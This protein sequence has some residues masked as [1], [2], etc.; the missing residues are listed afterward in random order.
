MG[1]PLGSFP[2]AW[3][4]VEVRWVTKWDGLI[5][6]SLS[7]IIFTLPFDL[8]TFNFDAAAFPLPRHGST[9]PFSKSLIIIDS[10]IILSQTIGQRSATDSRR[11]IFLRLD[12]ATST[13]I[14]NS[15]SISYRGPRGEPAVPGAGETEL[16][17]RGEGD[18]LDEVS[19]AGE[20]IFAVL[21]L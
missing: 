19:V 8:F 4:G 16:A 6:P 21:I 3:I 15:D 20:M 2:G 17:V 10:L 5:S 7:P 12:S 13:T 1:D 11:C 14:Q 9:T 18:V